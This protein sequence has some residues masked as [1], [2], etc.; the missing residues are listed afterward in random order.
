MRCWRIPAAR[1]KSRK[2]HHVPL[3]APALALLLALDSERD[4]DELVFPS[5]SGK[6]IW[7]GTFSYQL[8]K[9]G[10]KRERV[11]THG[12]R[13]SLR[14]YLAEQ[15]SASADVAESVLAHDKRSKIRQAYE[16]T[17][18]YE[19]RVPLMAAW[20]DFLDTADNDKP[21]DAK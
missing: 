7:D 10:Y 8:R 1:M 12:F 6:V 5:G 13:S 20:A 15:T 14:T 19:Q 9:M 21:V 18:F 17:R 4:P 11:C 3:S 16:R 2:E